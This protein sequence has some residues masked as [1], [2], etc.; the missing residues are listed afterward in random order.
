MEKR[1]DFDMNRKYV[2]NSSEYDQGTAQM[3][4]RQTFQTCRLVLKTLLV[5]VLAMVIVVMIVF[6]LI[7]FLL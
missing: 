4:W 6:L 3:S 5:P 2:Y 1:G 7:S